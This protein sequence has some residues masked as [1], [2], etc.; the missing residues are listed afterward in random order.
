MNYKDYYKIMGVARDASQDEIKRAYRKLARKYHPDVSKEANAEERFKEVQEAYEVL[1][2]PEKRAAYDQLGSNWRAGQ[3]FRPPPDWGRGFEFTGGFGA[4]DDSGFSDFFASLFGSRS[5][6]G[7]ARGGRARGFAAAGEDHVA[8]IQIDL[9]DAFRGGVQTIELKSPQVSEDGRVVLKPRTL[10]VNIPPGVIEGQ[11]IRLAG[12]GSAGI[13]GGPPGDLYLEIGFRPHRLFQVEGRDVTLTLPVA[14][15]EAALGAV[16]QTPTLAGPVELRIP[17]NAKAGQKLRLKGRGLPGSTPG[18]Q[19]VVLTIVLP[20][21]DSPR[22]R[23]LYRQMQE[24]LGFDPRAE[25][26]KSG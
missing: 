3:E 8:K 14:P 23:A 12:Q 20:P 24:E 1:K 17:A 11:R 9:E 7:R 10:K 25:L 6:F 5:P 4:E 19:Y 21:S 22:A 16:V 18:D 26:Y 2:D 13:G 15:W